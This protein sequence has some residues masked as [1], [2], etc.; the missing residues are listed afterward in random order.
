VRPPHGGLT[1]FTADD[2]AE[3]LRRAFER[4]AHP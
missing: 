2:D 3:Q 1:F 4:V